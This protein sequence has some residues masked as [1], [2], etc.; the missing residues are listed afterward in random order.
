MTHQEHLQRYA[1]L[2]VRHGAGLQRQQP[3]FIH[4]EVAHRDLAL[5]VAEAAYEVGGG[6]VSYRLV[7]PLQRALLIRRG[8]PEEIDL[9]H[10][11]DRRWFNRVVV[12]RGALISLRGDEDPR[13]MSE[14]AERH[15]ARHQRYSR[16]ASRSRGPFHTHGINRGLCPWVVAAAP[17]TAWARQVFPKLDDRAAISSLYECLFRFTYADHSDALQRAAARD[18]RLHARR[19][20]L[21]DLAI[22][23]LH[24]VGGGSDLRI[25][26]SPKARWLGGSKK[27]ASGQVFNANVPSEENFTTPDRRL[28]EGRLAATMPFRTKNGALVKDL[29]MTFEAGRVVDLSASHGAKTFGQWI[30]SDP[31]ARFLGEVA[32]VGLD[33]PIAQSGLFFEHTLLDENASCHVAL[34]KAYATCLEGGPDMTPDELEALGCNDSMIHTDMMFGSDEISVIASLSDRGEVPLLIDGQWCEPF[35]DPK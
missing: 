15:P 29:V 16:S 31:G 23:Q 19:R 12:H 21:D 13:L 32:L 7:D 28:T 2:L 30:D 11:E 33:S 34:G 9:I 6:P 20:L 14:L 5:R 10:E 26:L 18:H 35:L 4:G 17:T 24:I 1:D 22:R 25:G 3:L 8:S 27:T